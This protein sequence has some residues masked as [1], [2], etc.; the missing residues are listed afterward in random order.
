MKLL[1]FILNNSDK[2]DK[3]I[4][5]FAKNDLTGAT[6][7]NSSGVARKILESN[8][9]TLSTIVG[10][11][12]MILNRKNVPNNT[13]LMVVKEEKVNKVVEVIETVVGSLDEPGNG[14]VF[15][16]PVDFVKGFKH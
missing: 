5:E 10:S 15:T 9:E 8:D 1:V 12:K 13:I 14:I 3:L 7:I 2:L 6:V 16:V 4:H 11:L